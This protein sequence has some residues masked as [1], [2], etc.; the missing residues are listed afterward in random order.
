[1]SRLQTMTREEIDAALGRRVAP[2]RVRSRPKSAPRPRPQGTTCHPDRPHVAKGLCR[3]CYD[4]RRRPAQHKRQRQIMLVPR[5]A[6]W[7][8]GSGDHFH[9]IR[10]LGLEHVDAACGQHFGARAEFSAHPP[11]HLQMCDYCALVD[12]ESPAVYRLYDSQDQPLYI[13]CTLQLF[14]RLMSHAS[15]SIFWPQVIRVDHTA[16][17]TERE[18]L[19][20][21][22]E[23][24]RREQ[25]P[26]NIRHTTRD[27]RP[28]TRAARRHSRRLE[29]P[30]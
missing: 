20:A 27:P 3:Q 6:I 24:I 26:H 5:S 8:Y 12:H 16:Y 7:A 1:M 17:A 29:A 21:E 11:A 30:R 22:F 9:L 2:A 13:G 4:R 28:W 14:R 10:S 18:S 23:E 25:P 19:T 15:T